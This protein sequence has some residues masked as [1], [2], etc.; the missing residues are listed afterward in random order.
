LIKVGIFVK[1]QK[2]INTR[3]VSKK[4]QRALSR[5]SELVA[6]GLWSHE[7][8]EVL[9][10]ENY[11]SRNN[12]HYNIGMLRTICTYAGLDFPK[13]ESQVYVL[14]PD[15]VL[16]KAMI[17]IMSQSIYDIA[18]YLNI[19]RETLRVRL[20]KR[21][22]T[23][24]KKRNN[25]R[26]RMFFLK[27][28]EV[29]TV[30]RN[31]FLFDKKFERFLDMYTVVNN[32]NGYA[33]V[34]NHYFHRLVMGALKGEEVDHVSLDKSDNRLINLRKCTRSQNASNKEIKGYVDTKRNLT[35]RFANTVGPRK[36]FKTKSEAI[37]FSKRHHAA[38]NGQFSPYRKYPSASLSQKAETNFCD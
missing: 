18:D 8:I 6:Q 21:Y 23:L 36:Y 5:Y 7:A 30:A 32:G 1:F 9:Q 17:M 4:A 14:I 26:V 12:K 25:P 22:P 15:E 2:D 35:R 20:M 27:T 34:G 29:G 10:K 37:R 31:G 11:R 16:K 19:N 28:K 24:Y 38:K 33:K 13:M 3:T